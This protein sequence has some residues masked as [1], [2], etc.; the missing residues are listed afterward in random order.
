MNEIKQLH[1]WTPITQTGNN[2]VAKISSY[3]P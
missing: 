2:V 1:F 3:V